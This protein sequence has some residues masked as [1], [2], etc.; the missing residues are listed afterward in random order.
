[1]K[2][3]LLSMLLTIV[4][5]VPS[6]SQMADMPMKAQGG[7]A[8]EMGHMEKMSNMTG[9]CLGHA[10]KMGLTDDQIK[11]IMPIHREMEKK[12]ARFNADLKIAEIDLMEIM[13]VKDFD[14][15]K[16]SAMVKKIGDIKTSNHIEMLKSMK[17]MHSIL[18]DEQFKK[19]K[20]IMHPMMCGK[21]SA[22][23]MM[24]K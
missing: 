21:C 14:I 22:K 8:M 13:D 7:H 6:F 2:K 16:A 23:K 19:M 5:A 15:K 3:I 1:M 10:D 18:T 17:E 24:T 11:R 4:F 9:M 20:M 12:Y